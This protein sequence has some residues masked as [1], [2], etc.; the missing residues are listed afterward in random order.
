MK[1]DKEVWKDIQGYEGLYEVSNMGRIRSL[2]FGKIKYLKPSK[3]RDGY[4]HVIL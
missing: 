4:Y 2:K 3:D 1:N